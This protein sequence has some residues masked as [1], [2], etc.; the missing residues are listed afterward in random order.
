MHQLIRPKRM[1]K[2]LRRAQKNRKRRWEQMRGK[3]RRQIWGKLHEMQDHFCAYCEAPLIREDSHIE[4]FYPRAKYPEYTFE[5]RNLFGSCNNSWT[6]GIYKDSGRNPD[7]VIHDMIIKPD[8]ENP[9]GYFRYYKNGRMGVRG[10]LTDEAYHRGKATIRWFNLNHNALTQLRARH[11]APLKQ[12]EAEF[13]VWYDHCEENPDLLPILEE[14][15]WQL[16]KEQLGTA[17][18]AMKVHYIVEHLDLLSLMD[19]E[20][21]E[22]LL[23]DHAYEIG[24]R[25]QQGAHHKAK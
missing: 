25:H 23:K 18:Q 9:R 22:D 1:P 10:G 8:E 2:T 5:W 4:H 19:R 6:C 12:L 3:D 11:L 13:I 24:Q 20:L 15:L 21:I 17:F 7:K 14:E 16:L